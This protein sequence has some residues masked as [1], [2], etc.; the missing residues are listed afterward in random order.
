MVLTWGFCYLSVQT[1]APLSS[2]SFRSLPLWD[3][4]VSTSP[5]SGAFSPLFVVGFGILLT[6]LLQISCS[7]SHCLPISR[8]RNNLLVYIYYFSLSIYHYI[9]TLVHTQEASQQNPLRLSTPLVTQKATQY[10]ECTAQSHP[11]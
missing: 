6:R 7:Q 8:Q 4:T 5:S 10:T 9:L 2:A 1:L 11:R 3:S